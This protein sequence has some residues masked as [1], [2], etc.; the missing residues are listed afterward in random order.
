MSKIDELLGWH[1]GSGND[2]KINDGATGIRSVAIFGHVRPDGDCA[3]STLA[4]W[5]YIRDNYPQIKA[6]I[7]LEPCSD[8]YKILRGFDQVKKLYVGINSAGDCGE[9]SCD[10]GENCA[11]NDGIYDLAFLLDTPSFERVGANGADCIK[12]ARITC[13]IDHHISNP[14]NLCNTNIVEPNASSASEVLYFQLDPAKISKETAS[15]LYL[16]I[17]HDTGA[18]KY[19]CTGKRTMQV[20]GDLIE[21]GVDFAKIVNETYYTRTYKQT[22]VTGFVLQ[23]CKLG[24]DGKVV[25]SYISQADMDRFSVTPVELSNVID[26]LREVGGTEV[27]IFLYP[28]NGKYKISLRSNYVVDVNAIAKEFGGGG[29]TRAAGGDTEEAPEVAI[30]KILDLVAKQ[31]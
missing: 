22:L 28:V 2:G 23:N 29:H 17:V 7:F 16:G 12:K 1:Y 31:L 10:G 21:K 25:Y 11:N 19:S 8:T 18:F 26:T 6:D 20:V 3:G 9:K 13:N 30:Q 4:L 15:C 14:L 27:T 24:L 5:N